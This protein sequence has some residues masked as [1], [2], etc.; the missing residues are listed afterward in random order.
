[1][2][3][4]VVV[5]AQWGDEAKGKIVDFLTQKSKVLIRYS[6]GGNAGHTV[7]HG[8]TKYKFHHLPSGI[9]NPDLKCFITS[10][11]VVDLDRLITELD[12][13]HEKGIKTDNLKISPDCHVVMPFH[14]M[15]DLYNESKLGNGQVGTT[16]QGIGPV[17]SD[18]AL[19]VSLRL[20]DLLKGYESVCSQPKFITF[21]DKYKHLDINIDEVLLEQTKK[22]QKIKAMIVDPFWEIQKS[23]SEKEMIVAE[24]AQGTFLDLNHGEYPYVTS[25][26]PIS[27]GACLGTGLGP[28]D[29]THIIGVV[30]A[31]STRVGR[32]PMPTEIFDELAQKIRDVGHEYGTTTGRP[33]R[34]GWLDLVALRYSVAVNSMDTIA[35]TLLD[36]LTNLE[37]IKV[38]VGYRNIKDQVVTNE[39]PKGDLE[40][41]EPVYENLPSWKEDITGIRTYEDLPFEAKNYICFVEKFLSKKVEFV[42]VGPAREQTIKR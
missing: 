11:A 35:L 13:L 7:Q 27:G 22:I 5:G 34:I 37:T 6:G 4:T 42:S 29:I 31:Y 39:F 17:Y 40:S 1:M 26:H 36:V 30:K 20:G 25:S 8:K 15:Q 21:K 10:N 3:V 33:R 23:L 32:G 38:C 28:R 9:L 18:K 16:G 2:S 14:K 24:G 19:R 41:Y 12:T